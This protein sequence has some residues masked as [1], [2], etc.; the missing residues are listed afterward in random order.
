MKFEI[1]IKFDGKTSQ[2]VT[3]SCNVVGSRRKLLRKAFGSK[4]E[5]ENQV[6]I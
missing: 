5:V 4:V 3:M 1:A 2:K 6:L